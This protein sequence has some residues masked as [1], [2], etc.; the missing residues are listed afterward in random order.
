MDFVMGLPR[1]PQDFD[2]IWVV[3]DRLTKNRTFHAHTRGLL[4]KQVNSTLCPRSNQTAWHT[5]EYSIRSE[6]QILF[7][8][9]KKFI[10]GHGTKLQL[11]TAVHLQTNKQSERI[12]LVLEDMLRACVM[13]FGENW[14]RRLPLV[15]FAYNNS[16][17]ST[18]GMTSVWNTL[19][20]KM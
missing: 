8:T 6:P 9:L 13:N 17:Q 7:Q 10:G 5:W 14:A 19:R 16:Y 18:I 4:C 15:E 11:S 12:I 3:V 2:V 20:L 1:T